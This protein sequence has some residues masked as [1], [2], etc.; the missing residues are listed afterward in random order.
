MAWWSEALGDI[1]GAGRKPS[2]P[3]AAALQDLIRRRSLPRPLLETLIEAR[4]ERLFSAVA[5]GEGAL[6][7]ADKVAGSM[8]LLAARVLDPEAPQDPVRLGGRAFGLGQL[9]RSG[10]LAPQIGAP[11]LQQSLAQ[12]NAALSGL[13]ARAFPAVAAAT[14]ARHRRS[15]GQL[16]EISQQLRLVVAVAR[17]RL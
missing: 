6:A 5:D 10:A 14:L 15:D 4:R 1:F 12:A 3:V 2:H 13:S 11:L 9:I 16:S 8:A 17:G 7:W